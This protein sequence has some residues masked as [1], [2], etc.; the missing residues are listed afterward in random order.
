MVFPEIK[1][2]SIIVSGD[3]FNEILEDS[4]LLSHFIFLLYFSNSLIAYK[5]S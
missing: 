2:Y 4:S 3:Y 1:L 5:M